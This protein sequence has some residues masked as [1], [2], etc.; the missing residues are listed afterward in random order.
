MAPVSYHPCERLLSNS[1]NIHISLRGKRG[2]QFKD[3]ELVLFCRKVLF[4]GLRRK[5]WHTQSTT[6]SEVGWVMLCKEGLYSR[7]TQHQ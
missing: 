3:K 6:A 5:H 2:S 1:S 4:Q 7:L